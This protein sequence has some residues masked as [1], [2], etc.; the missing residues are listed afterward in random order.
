MP[1]LKVENYNELKDIKKCVEERM[2]ECDNRRK[3]LERV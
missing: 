3:M 1:I 2:E